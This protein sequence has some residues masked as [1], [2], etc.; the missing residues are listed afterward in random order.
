MRPTI[1]RDPEAL[2]RIG[3]LLVVV[4]LLIGAFARL[5]AWVLVR[6]RQLE[7][8]RDRDGA[9]HDRRGTAELRRRQPEDQLHGSAAIA[10]S[11]RYSNRSITSVTV[12]VV[13]Q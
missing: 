8:C 3:A 4:S 9:A 12:L 10:V 13:R 11:V 1:E 6:G 7:L 5:P 2:M